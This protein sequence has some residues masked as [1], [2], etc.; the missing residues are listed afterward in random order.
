MSINGRVEQNEGVP[1]KKLLQDTYPT[2]YY[3]PFATDDVCAP[4][5]P[6][7]AYYGSR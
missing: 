4:V 7:H 5:L 6:H 3:L 1:A 2:N